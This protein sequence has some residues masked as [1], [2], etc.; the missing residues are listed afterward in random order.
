MIGNVKYL[1]LFAAIIIFFAVAP[2][3][4]ADGPPI[5]FT[6]T[7]DDC[8]YFFNTFTRAGESDPTLMIT[9]GMGDVRWQQVFTDYTS[10]FRRQGSYYTYYSLPH[11]RAYAMNSQFDIVDSWQAIGLT[12]G[13]GVHEF[14]LTPDYHAIYL[15]YH[16]REP[17]P[18]EIVAGVLPTVTIQST[19]IQEQDQDKNLVF[20]WA[21]LDHL[22]VT[23]TIGF[24]NDD[25]VLDYC[26]G[27]SVEVDYDGHLL[28]SCR[29][30]DS[31][32]KI[33]R[34]TGEVIWV[35]GG[36]LNEFDFQGAAPFC[37]QHDARRTSDGTITIFSNGFRRD[38]VDINTR[39]LEYEID[40]AG[41]VITEVWSYK[42]PLPVLTRAQ[43]GLWKLPNGHY[44]I[45]WGT[46]PALSTT[47]NIAFTE[48]MSDG[49][50]VLEVEFGDSAY[51]YQ[52]RKYS[53]LRTT[54]LPIIIKN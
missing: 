40:E 4:Y 33:N 36:Q 21:D 16:L 50:K 7:T 41:R 46:N 49:T 17:T 20:Q 25:E 18:A 19:V 45:D 5:T 52:T 22:P 13:M 35:L 1:S 2:T 54:W 44:L 38:C 27:N 24:G 10:V 31:V 6:I 37:W 3:A 30:L 32:V 14:L 29:T 51:A 26:H 11:R 47:S 12:P 39:A 53:L 34:Q 43:G 15:I 42:N 23:A 28:L 8:C 48:V 9:D